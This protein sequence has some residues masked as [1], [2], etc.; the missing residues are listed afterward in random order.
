MYTA[1]A[2][3]NVQVKISAIPPGYMRNFVI[4][5]SSQNDLLLNQA[6]PQAADFPG[7]LHSPNR[8]DAKAF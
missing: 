5:Q 8:S 6:R 1:N 3:G 4:G 7:L 2:N